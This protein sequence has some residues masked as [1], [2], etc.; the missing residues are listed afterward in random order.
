[1]KGFVESNE[2]AEHHPL[3]ALVELN[4]QARQDLLTGPGFPSFLEELQEQRQT[5]LWE[6]VVEDNERLDVDVDSLRLNVGGLDTQLAA[7]V[8]RA[9]ATRRLPP[10]TMGSL[11]LAHVKGML[12]YGPP[13]LKCV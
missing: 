10:G 7:I 11:G 2:N 1:M 4:A 13:G 6:E 5:S 9:F 3:P 8:R 12:L